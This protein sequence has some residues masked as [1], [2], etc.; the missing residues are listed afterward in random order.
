MVRTYQGDMLIG[1]VGVVGWLSGGNVWFGM[2]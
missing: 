2:R 1:W